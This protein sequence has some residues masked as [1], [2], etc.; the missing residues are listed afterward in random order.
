MPSPD[1]IRAWAASGL[2]ERDWHLV[3]A[4]TGV[5]R[6]DLEDLVDRLGC[7]VSVDFA[8]QVEDTDALLAGASILL[9]PAPAE[10][11]GLS[12]VEAM[13]HGLAVVA[14]RGGAHVE[15]VGED[16]L[17]FPP[18]DV[19]AA[20]RHLE[21]LGSDPELVTSIGHALRYRQ[22]E[23]FSVALHLDRLEALYRSVA[24][25]SR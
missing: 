16:G 10:P 20:A 25:G 22:Q 24:T 11:F 13:A 14:A 2:A 7:A 4:G 1:L 9:A 18:G 3:V 5:L 6:P 21:R 8:G 15:T 23:R 12:V 17:L 19:G